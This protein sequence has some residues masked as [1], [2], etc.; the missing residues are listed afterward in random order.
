MSSLGCVCFFENLLLFKERLLISE[1][2][3]PGSSIACDAELGINRGLIPVEFDINEVLT[4]WKMVEVSMALSV[5]SLR[6]FHVLDFKAINGITVFLDF[7]DNNPAVAV[8]ILAVSIE[9]P[10]VFLANADVVF[11]LVENDQAH[12]RVAATVVGSF[13]E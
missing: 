6:A 11:T 12:Q 1:E 8:V 5:P 3:C 13:H 9:A 10:L 7:H 4:P 2:K